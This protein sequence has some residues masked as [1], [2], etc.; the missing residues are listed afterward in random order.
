MPIAEC[1]LESEFGN[2][3]SEWRIV[4]RKELL[5]KER[6]IGNWQSPIGNK[7]VHGKESRNS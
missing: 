7:L 5:N 1:Q 6:L 2:V 3:N 4:N